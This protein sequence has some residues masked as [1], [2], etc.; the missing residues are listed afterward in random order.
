MDVIILTDPKE[1]AIAAAVI[2]SNRVDT[3]SKQNESKGL[4][5]PQR[6]RTLKSTKNSKA[7]ELQYL[8][9][10]SPPLRPIQKRMYNVKNFV[11]ILLK[12]ILYL[13]KKNPD[14]KQ[15]IGILN[16]FFMIIKKKF[17]LSL[18]F[19]CNLSIASHENRLFVK[20]I[21]SI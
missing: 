17:I 14:K 21:I 19:I 2:E 15:I 20:S 13:D 11:K 6:I 1:A 5:S 12:L 7:E 4:N 16:T 18:N 10:G 3:R 8:A 9:K